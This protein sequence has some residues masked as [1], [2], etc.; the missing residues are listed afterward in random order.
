M[1]TGKTADSEFFCFRLGKSVGTT[2]NHCGFY[3]HSRKRK[4]FFMIFQDAMPCSGRS[5][6]SLANAADVLRAERDAGNG[7]FCRRQAAEDGRSGGSEHDAPMSS[8][9][10]AFAQNL[11]GRGER[12]IFSGIYVLPGKRGF[13]L[14]PVL[15]PGKTSRPEQ[16][17]F[18]PDRARSVAGQVIRFDFEL[19]PA[20]GSYRSTYASFLNAQTP[21]K[22]D[23]A[24]R[25]AHINSF[26]QSRYDATAQRTYGHR[27]GAHF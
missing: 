20:R 25:G 8:C 9:A 22:E 27:A 24:A 26:P 11:R 4:A 12:R 3:R 19:A 2:P 10:D 17:L 15:S 23:N 18:R 21:A 5:K 6:R 7:A 1:S 16:R 13:S 14:P